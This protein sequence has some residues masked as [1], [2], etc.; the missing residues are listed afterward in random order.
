MTSDI[1]LSTYLKA[2]GRLVYFKSF[3]SSGVLVTNPIISVVQLVD[4]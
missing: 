2:S 4:P 3:P 1:A